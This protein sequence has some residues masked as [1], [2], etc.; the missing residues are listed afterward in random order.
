MTKIACARSPPL[1]TGGLSY[2]AA[3]PPQLR[4]HWCLLHL[5]IRE[6]SRDT[7]ARLRIE[8]PAEAFGRSAERFMARVGTAG[9]RAAVIFV[10]EDFTDLRLE[11]YGCDTPPP[12]V[13]L[14]ARRVGR[15][16]AAAILAARQPRAFLAAAR[17]G[18]AS[19]PA[20]LRAALY[21]IATRA[22]P[23]GSYA[24]WVRLFDAWPPTRL[25]RLLDAPDR[26]GWPRIHATV[27]RDAATPEAAVA[28]TMQAL[29]RSAVAVS[30]PPDVPA[31]AEYVAVLQAGEVVPPHALALAGAEILRRGRPPVLLADEDALDGAG[32]RVDP[33]F[34]PSPCRTLMLSGTLSRG[35]WLVRRDVFDV[36]FPAGERWAEVARLRLWLALFEAGQAGGCVRIPHVLTHRRPDTQAAP[37]AALEAVAD[38]HRAR[39]PPPPAGRLCV[40]VPTAARKPHVARCLQAVLAATDW[41]GLEMLLVVSQPQ[42][43][44]A[45]Q[46]ALLAPALADP[47]VRLLHNPAASFNYAAANNAAARATDADLL[48]LLNDDVA[49][50]DAGWL[51]AMAAQL[52]DAAVAAV[53][54]RL[55]YADHTVQHAGIIMGLGGLCE[56]AF[57]FLPQNAPGYAGRAMLDHEVSAVTGACLLVRRAAWRQVGGM[58]EIFATGFNDVD[59][60]MKLRA[61]GHRI[62]LAAG[63]ELFH[64]ES[65][66]LGHHYAGDAAPRELLDAGLIWRRW[67]AVCRDD[68]YYNPNLS[69]EFGA[70]W[71]PGFPPREQGP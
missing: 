69:L 39:M 59:F 63:A 9:R 44:D 40:I 61:A 62:V 64:Y 38:A 49:P 65:L 60:C 58:D 6:L 18:G 20:R 57:R 15:A 35:L 14:D 41:P 25:A 46:R 52:A 48:C 51:R 34:K 1:P 45:E 13:V 29:R 54:A 66:S 71:Q 3:I 21:V 16:G 11:L 53:G 23:P 32:R 70:D 30:L 68:P 4:G 47:R 28:A 55:Y 42:P 37:A 8:G 67:G 2:A 50:M 26:A 27:F 56:H 7:L 19:L 33:L 36:W 12:Q 17:R 10:P 5:S 43:P 24:D 31:D 22:E